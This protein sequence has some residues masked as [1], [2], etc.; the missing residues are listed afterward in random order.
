MKVKFSST[1]HGKGKL[2]FNDEEVSGATAI[3]INVRVDEINKAV[4]EY[5]RDV[6][7]FEGEAEVIAVIEGRRYQLIEDE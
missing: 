6:V 3:Q 7:E 4:V 1:S 5:V 2:F